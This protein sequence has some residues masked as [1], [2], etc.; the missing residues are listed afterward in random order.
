MILNDNAFI[1][2]GVEN[3]E[4][5]KEFLFLCLLPGRAVDKQRAGFRVHD[6]LSGVDPV[7]SGEPVTDRCYDQIQ[8]KTLKP[9]EFQT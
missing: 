7:I 2:R 5:K 1:D 9:K 3:Q 6:L 8:R 4:N